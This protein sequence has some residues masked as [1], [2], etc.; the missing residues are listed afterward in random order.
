MISNLLLPLASIELEDGADVTL[1]SSARVPIVGE[2]EEEEDE[3]KGEEEEEGE[4]GE[5]EEG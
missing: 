3:E 1:T 5:K 2:E 4:V